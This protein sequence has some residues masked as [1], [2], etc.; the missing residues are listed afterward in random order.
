[1]ESQG[2]ISPIQIP[3]GFKGEVGVETTEKILKES[4]AKAFILI[5]LESQIPCATE[6]RGG[7][8]GSIHQ[9][10]VQASMPPNYQHGIY[11]QILERCP[12]CGSD[13]PDDIL[14]KCR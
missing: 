12:N 6:F 9:M 5:M 7:R 13:D 11:V 10:A 3:G 2:I 8:C 1:M 4:G 14:H